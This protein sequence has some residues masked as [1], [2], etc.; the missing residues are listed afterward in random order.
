M[1]TDSDAL[2]KIANKYIICQGLHYKHI[3]L[4]KGLFYPIHFKLLLHYP[5][6]IHLE[7]PENTSPQQKIDW[8]FSVHSE[9]VKSLKCAIVIKEVNDT[10]DIDSFEDSYHEQDS[11]VCI[12][13]SKLKYNVRLQRVLSNSV[14]SANGV[15]SYAS[16]CKDQFASLFEMTRRRDILKSSSNKLAVSLEWLVAK[17]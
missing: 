8:T 12:N 10:N 7:A 3:P 15:E 6:I 11:V 2:S 13:C 5:T 1:I 17:L 16:R 14:T 9:N 4:Q